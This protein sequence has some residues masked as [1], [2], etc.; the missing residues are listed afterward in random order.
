MGALYKKRGNLPLFTDREVRNS[1]LSFFCQIH[2][3]SLC[4]GYVSGLCPPASIHNIKADLL[5]FGQ[6]FKSFLNDRGIV[7]ENI[8]AAIPLN[9]TITFFLTEPLH[10]TKH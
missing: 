2:P 10:P 8:T 6:G 9:E 7:D 3:H 5:T 1:V 4:F